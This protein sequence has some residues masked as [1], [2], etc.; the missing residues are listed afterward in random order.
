MRSYNVNS[1]ENKENTLNVKV[2]S[3]LLACTAVVPLSYRT[4]K[5]AQI[6]AASIIIIPKGPPLMKLVFMDEANAV[7]TRLTATYLCTITLLQNVGDRRWM[8]EG[9]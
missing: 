4:K 8:T 9:R 5:N 7:M 3:K 2:L 6:F 1:R